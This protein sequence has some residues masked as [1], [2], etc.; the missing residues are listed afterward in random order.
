VSPEQRAEFDAL[1]RATID[2]LPSEY[3]RALDHVAV[4]IEDRPSKELMHQLR[5]EGVL[6]DADDEILGLHSGRMLTEGWGS[7]SAEL[8][9]TIHLFREPIVDAAGGWQERGAVAEEVRITLLHELGHHFGLEE[10]DLD[11][12]GYG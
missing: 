7:E 1:V 5:Q 9:S 8:P 12:L 4:I 10:D 3:R 2:A 11:E 6:E